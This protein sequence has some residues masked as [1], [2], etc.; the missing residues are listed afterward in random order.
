MEGQATVD[1]DLRNVSGG[2]VLLD[3]PSNQWGGGLGHLL[4]RGTCGTQE[5]VARGWAKRGGGI[6]Q[7]LGRLMPNLVMEGG[8]GCG[9]GQLLWVENV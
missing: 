1:E 9:E 5:G 2:G 4:V 3:D 7:L 8:P 6:L